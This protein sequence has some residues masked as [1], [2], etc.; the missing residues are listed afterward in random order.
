VAIASLMSYD[1]VGDWWGRIIH[2]N[3]PKSYQN[4]NGTGTNLDYYAPIGSSNAPAP[5]MQ[6]AAIRVKNAGWPAAKIVVGFDINPTYWYGGTFSDGRGPTYIRKP[7]NGSTSTASSD[8]DFSAQWPTLSQIP[9]DS[10]HFDPIAQT[11]WAHTGTS[12]SNDKLW[13]MTALPGRDSAVWAT[14]QVVDSMDIGGVMF[15]N[16]GSE[17]WNT[18]SVPPGGKGWFFSQIRKHFNYS[19]TTPPPPPPQDVTPPSIDLT[20]P[21]NGATVSG[22]VAL[23]AQAS[24]NVGVASVQFYVNGSPLGGAVTAAPWTKSWNTAG[25]ANGNYAIRATASDAAGLKASDSATVVINAPPPPPGDSIP[26]AVSVTSPAAADTVSGSVTVAVSATD[27]SGVSSVRLIVDGAQ[28]AVT[29][30]S[31]PYA[32]SWNSASVPDGPHTIGAEATDAAGL[33]SSASVQVYV[34]NALPPP[35]P[36]TGVAGVYGDAIVSPWVNASWGSTNTFSSPEKVY[37]GSYA[38]K[39]QQNAWGAF[40]VHNGSWTTP[41]ALNTDGFDSLRFAVYPE[42]TGLSIAVFLENDA[43][44]PFGSVTRS[45]IPA[46]QWSVVSIPIGALNPSSQVVHRLNIQNNTSQTRVYHIDRVEF[47]GASSAPVVVLAAPALASPA[48]GAVDQPSTTTLSWGAVDGASSYHLQLAL[49][50]QFGGLV[51]DLPDLAGTSYEA[52]PLGS[53]TTYYWRVRAG[54][55]GEQGPYSATSSFT[56][57]AATGALKYDRLFVDFGKVPVGGE[58]TD[59]VT[60]E[61]DGPSQRKIVGISS[62]SSVFE[63]IPGG[64]VIP[65][66]GLQKLFIKYKPTKKTNNSSR[67]ISIID[68]TNRVDT[69]R[70]VGSGVSAPR[71]RNRGTVAIGQIPPEEVGT[72]ELYVTNEGDLDLVIASVTSTTEG[73]SV[74]PTSATIAPYDSVPFRITV[75]TK[76]KG[77]GKGNNKISG[78]LVFSNN[79]FG[80]ADSVLVEATFSGGDGGDAVPESYSLAQ[81]YPN[82]FNPT[83]TIGFG[84]PYDSRVTVRIYNLFGQEVATVFEGNLGAGYG[85]VQWDG[86]NDAGETLASGVY[87]YRIEAVAAQGPGET[88]TQLRRMLLVK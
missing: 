13:V 39:T 84:L 10:V 76:G 22:T 44:G 61:N 87:F 6:Q 81:N 51:A 64:L 15:W 20:A 37:D 12:L 72:Q 40:S 80:P 36:D 3:A 71:Q 63:A 14:R 85:S 25:L 50:E 1:Y 21:A 75:D 28:T 11:Y 31:A 27:A 34:K 74:S 18:S 67:V 70:V 55:S 83:T 79:G 19:G 48:S 41:V 47:T 4:W 38:L 16:L 35:P 45:N 66:G 33:K 2:D 73:I 58:K 59:S 46:K 9:A 5:S 69:I 30:A 56:T 77:K 82:P 53:Q 68:S 7:T 8:L 23:T 54:G 62:G 29:D 65:P 26:P 49:D 86:Q 43:T 78:Y 52:G 24:D 42:T 57:V 60:I 32:L 17:V 88:F